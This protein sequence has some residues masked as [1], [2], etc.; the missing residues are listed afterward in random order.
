MKTIIYKNH[1]ISFRDEGQGSTIVLLHGFMESLQIWNDFAVA[2]SKSFRVVRIDLPGHGNTPVMDEMHSMALMA[3]VVKT[4]LDDL[5]IRKC[6]MIGHSMGGYVTLAFAKRFREML[7]GFC[8]FHSHAAADNA[9]AR[10]NRRRTINIVKMNRAGFIQQFI[11]DL[12]AASNIEKFADEIQV[13]QKQAASTS[14]KSIIAALEGMKERSSNFEL[15]INTKLPV[16]FVCGKEDSRIPVQTV[17]AQAILPA[18]AEILIL[19]DVGHMGYIEA[20]KETLEMIEGFVV[21]VTAD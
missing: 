7:S 8:L 19:A 9:E 17:M 10:E 1:N 13:L 2:L 5:K 20:K 6:V 4:V 15:L 18:H 3:E 16:L 21:R 12:F 14:A 11:P